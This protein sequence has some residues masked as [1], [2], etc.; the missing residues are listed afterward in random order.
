MPGFLTGRLDMFPC[1]L[2]LFLT[3]LVET[4]TLIGQ[5]LWRVLDVAYLCWRASRISALSSRPVVARLLRERG[6]S[7]TSPGSSLCLLSIYTPFSATS[8]LFGQ[9]AILYPPLL[10]F[11]WLAIA[12]WWYFSPWRSQADRSQKV[13]FWGGQ[14]CVGFNSIVQRLYVQFHSCLPDMLP[15]IYTSYWQFFRKPLNF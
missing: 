5:W 3:V 7:F 9:C 14:S 11:Q 2:S 12:K 13:D 4:L 1:C 15:G 10:S 8:A 6:Q